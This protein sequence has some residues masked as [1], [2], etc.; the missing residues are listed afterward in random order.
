MIKWFR[1]FIHNI[2]T[3]QK[4]A[5]LSRGIRSLM[6]KASRSA[7]TVR[8]YS[9]N[10]LKTAIENY[11]K[12]LSSQND[13]IAEATK[14]KALTNQAFLDIDQTTIRAAGII[15]NLEKIQDSDPVKQLFHALQ[16][17]QRKAEKA[18]EAA[19]HTLHVATFYPG[20]GRFPDNLN[21]TLSQMQDASQELL[22]A[23]QKA[24]TLNNKLTTHASLAGFGMLAGNTELP[25]HP[26]A[27]VGE[28]LMNGLNT[29]LAVAETVECL[30]GYN[31]FCILEDAVIDRTV[32]NGTAIGEKARTRLGEVFK[33]VE[34]FGGE[35]ADHITDPRTWGVGP[36]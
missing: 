21:H 32:Q 26:V 14:L 27:Q 12:K 8:N 29:G 6:T 11:N 7:E 9:F 17:A 15:D 34:K 5:R 10:E 31:P 30:G 13:L 18:H 1:K 22:E 4:M 25:D 3:I 28:T 20:A 16:D 23:F 33:E 2:A 36:R 35:A 24:Q 19:R